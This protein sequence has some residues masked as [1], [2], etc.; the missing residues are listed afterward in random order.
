M[1]GLRGWPSG[2]VNGGEVPACVFAPVFLT[3]SGLSDFGTW[4]WPDADGL[5]SQWDGPEK[6][7]IPT[8]PDGSL[9]FYSMPDLKVPLSVSC[10]FRWPRVCLTVSLSLPVSVAEL[11]LSVFLNMRLIFF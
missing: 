1:P 4:G 7:Q 11:V 6:T 8:G 3:V 2:F 5:T 10:V 9:W